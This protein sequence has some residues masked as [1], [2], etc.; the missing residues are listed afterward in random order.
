[1]SGNVAIA[2]L[3]AATVAAVL[4]GPHS[5]ISYVS[6]G[7]PATVTPGELRNYAETLVEVRKIEASLKDALAQAPTE[8]AP[9][10]RHQA[11]VA[12]ASALL[13][14]ELRTTRFNQIS[15]QVESN[16]RV[17]RTVRQYVMR[18]QLG[19]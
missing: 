15:Q 17:R 4:P 12:I 2:I 9:M 13:H 5:A 6:R 14:H 1:M 3:S 7:L 10:L 19:I 18:E 8:A 11:D 16:S